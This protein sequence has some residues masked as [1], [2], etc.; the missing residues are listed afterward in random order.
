MASSSPDSY[1]VLLC[2][3]DLKVT[4]RRIVLVG[5]TG[6]GKS[7]SGNTILGRK[8]FRAAT[9]SSSVTRECWKEIGEVAGTETVVVDTPGL[10]DTSLSE[11][12][13]KREMS[14][15]INM[16][17]PGPHAIV[18]V[19]QVGPFTE[20]EKLSVEKVRVLFG[21]E[22]D[23]YTLILFT[24]GDR[25]TSQIDEYV[26]EAHPNLKALISR[27]GGRY[28]AFN[29]TE[30]QNREQV[31]KFL[32]KID[33]MVAANGG[34]FY[35]NDRY[36]DVERKLRELEE[37]LKQ[38]YENKL[39]EQERELTLKFEDDRQRLEKI[40][41]TLEGALQEREEKIK[42]LELLDISRQ[43]LMMETKR[44]YEEKIRSVRQEA[45]RKQISEQML[46]DAFGR[47]QGL[48]L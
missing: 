39:K 3:S 38:Q 9:S 23:R 15:C 7:S 34:G 1:K 2:I 10:F 45:E 40:I 17:A 36:K 27:C 29:N 26:G 14:K 32:E 43:K 12:E 28:H 21:E 24:H 37:D 47:L 22:A 5:K 11:Q 41:G 19:I 13:L 4:M 18:L 20:E 30:I 16:T 42:E 44:F 25:L 31:F 46:I 6:A 33:N 35:T 8:S 48:H